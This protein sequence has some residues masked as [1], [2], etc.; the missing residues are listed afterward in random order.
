L[1]MF[2]LEL[3]TFIGVRERNYQR[4]MNKSDNIKLMKIL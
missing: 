2:H 1:Y 4:W 3:A